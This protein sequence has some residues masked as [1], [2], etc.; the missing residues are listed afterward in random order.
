MKLAE[1]GEFGF[2]ARVRQ[3]AESCADLV[4]GIGDDCAASRPAPGEL[5]LTSTDLLI[6]DVHF[7]RAWSDPRTLG[8]KSVSVNVS[9]VAAMGGKPASLYLGL[10][11]PGGVAVE[12]LDAFADGVLEACA[13]Y[14]AV[15]AGGD[16]CRSPGPWFISVTVQGRVPEGELLTRQGA[17]PGDLLWVSGRL[18]DSALALRELLAGGRP[19]PALAARHL[20]PSA[21]VALG[22]ALA[23]QGLATA[24]IDVSDGLLADLGHILDSSV[25]GARVERD[26]LPLSSLFRDAL[27]A[28]PALLDLALAGGEDYELLFTSPPQCAA[29]VAAL[30]ADGVPVTQ[31][32]RILPQEDGLLLVDALGRPCPL[33]R[34]GFDHFS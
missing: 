33:P 29:A 32:G 17:R 19:A 28:E 14:G 9:D 20:D 27:T 8:R 16:T 4:L 22:R 31:I 25:V 23:V 2:I 5:L 3:R 1:I 34:R 10:G 6:E 7:R 18:G 24:M 12:D 26:A 30:A 13:E 21:R 11:I 15:L